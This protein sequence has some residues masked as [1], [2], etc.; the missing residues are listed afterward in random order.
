MTM[1]QR[2]GPAPTAAACAGPGRA[3]GSLRTPMAPPAARG[4]GASGGGMFEL[5][6]GRG[7]IQYL[8][9]LFHPDAPNDTSPEGFH[10][11]EP[12][13]PPPPPPTHPPPP[14]PPP[15]PPPQPPH[16]PTHHHPTPTQNNHT[17]NPT[18][19]THP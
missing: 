12:P 3:R 2:A 6:P 9:S 8:A 10:D 11:P 19:H 14:T 18:K 15:P 17:T 1:S 7:Q 4:I 13:P 5:G 16:H